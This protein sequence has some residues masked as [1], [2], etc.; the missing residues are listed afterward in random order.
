MPEIRHFASAAKTLELKAEKIAVR[1]SRGPLNSCTKLNEGSKKTTPSLHP[2][3]T[4]TWSTRS[5]ITKSTQASKKT[6]TASQKFYPNN[7]RVLTKKRGSLG[8]TSFSQHL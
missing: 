3:T 1:V 2:L 5:S 6:T 7:H 4:K 8:A